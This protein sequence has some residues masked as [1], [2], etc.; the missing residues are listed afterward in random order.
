MRRVRNYDD[1]NCYSVSRLIIALSEFYESFKS[2]KSKGKM[3]YSES[4]FSDRIHLIGS[5]GRNSQF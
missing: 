2:F 3:L 5:Y 4:M 1:K